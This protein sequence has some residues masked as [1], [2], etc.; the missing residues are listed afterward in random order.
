MKGKQMPNCDIIDLLM[1]YYHVALNKE[2]YFK[3][4]NKKYIYSCN[5][6]K[7]EAEAKAIRQDIHVV[8]FSDAKS[9]LQALESGKF[10]NSTIQELMKT[11]D[12][13][14]AEHGVKVTLQWIPGHVNIQGNERADTLAKRGASCPQP[15]V[16]TS[17]EN[18]KQTIKAN[19]KEE[20]MNE[21]TSINNHT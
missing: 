19:K 6:S 11:I 9:V 21:Y 7:Y 4:K 13:L 20:W 10:D 2:F 14:I 15:D 3:K 8:V 17:I 12:C 18:T 1:F 16:P 5:S